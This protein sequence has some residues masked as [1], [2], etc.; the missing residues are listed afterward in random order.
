ML[1]PACGSLVAL[2]LMQSS[3]FGQV[4]ASCAGPQSVE[5]TVWRGGLASANQRRTLASSSRAS[6]LLSLTPAPAASTLH[7]NRLSQHANTAAKH[8]TTDWSAGANLSHRPHVKTHHIV[9]VFVHHMES[10]AVR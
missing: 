7:Y 1:R 2:L 9:R 10:I 5:V 6:G 8:R 3:A 4:L